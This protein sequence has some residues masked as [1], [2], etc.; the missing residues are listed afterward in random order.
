M[1]R[2]CSP[3]AS[4]LKHRLREYFTAFGNSVA[5]RRNYS[6]NKRESARHFSHISTCPANHFLSTQWEMKNLHFRNFPCRAQCKRNPVAWL[7]PTLK[8]NLKLKLHYSFKRGRN[9]TQTD[10]KDNFRVLHMT[11]HL[12]YA[13]PA[14]TKTQ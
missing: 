4:S 14:S 11:D 8:D 5:I 2:Q 1:F 13:M 10:I 3:S 7:T 9:M 6:C 12:L